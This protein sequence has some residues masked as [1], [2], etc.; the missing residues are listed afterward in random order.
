M[1]SSEI[2]LKA[3]ELLDGKKGKAALMI[4]VMCAISAVVNYLVNKILPGE[5][6]VVEYFGVEMTQTTANPIASLITS[7]VS[8]FLSLGM[9][10]YFMKIARG[11]DPEITELFSKGNILLKVFVSAFLAGLLIICGTVAFIIPGI[12]IALGL[13]M[14]NYIYIDNPEVGMVE[15]LK[16]SWNMMKGHKWSYFCLGLSFLGWILLTP[17]TLFLLFFWLIPYMGVSTVVF[18]EEIKDA[19]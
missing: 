9:A 13:S 1:K 10:S 19:E 15:V 4:L 17:F 8:L 12:I 5:T 18:Y 14:I 2:K 16:Q 7:F 3:K 6:K 11:E